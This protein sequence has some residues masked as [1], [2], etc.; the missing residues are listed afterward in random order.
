[1]SEKEMF[2]NVWK[3]EFEITKKILKAYPVEHADLKPGAKG[4]TAKELIGVFVGEQFVAEGA[5]NGK[6]DM[7]GAGMKL[8]DSIPDIISH[9]ESNFARLYEKAKNMSDAQWN[10]DVEFPAGPGKMGKFRAADVLWITV[11]DMIHHRGQLSIYFRIAG[12][13]LPSIYGPSADEPWM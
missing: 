5:M 6:I 12:A 8:P 11:H 10:A 1:M 4:R 2:L 13:K 7:S 3:M 9:Y